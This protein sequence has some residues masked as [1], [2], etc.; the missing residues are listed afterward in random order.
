[1]TEPIAA[2]IT[3]PECGA[4]NDVVIHDLVWRVFRGF[5]PTDTNVWPEDEVQWE[6]SESEDMTCAECEHQ[7]TELEMLCVLQV[8]GGGDVVV[9]NQ[10]EV[11][12]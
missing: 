12:P 3:C 7:Y 9:C 1:M 8:H 11:T 4:V 2:V 10:E 5:D 6:T